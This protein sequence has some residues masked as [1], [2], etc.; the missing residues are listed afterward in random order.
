MIRTFIK[1][2]KLKQFSVISK[3][4]IFRFVSQNIISIMKKL[5]N[6]VLFFVLGLSFV[7]AQGTSP[8]ITF[9]ESEFDF[10]TIK[11]EGGSIT[12]VFNFKNSGN[13]PL[14]LSN[15][16]A[17]C[18]CTTPDWPKA[19][20]SPNQDGELKVTFNPSGRV[21][22][23]N[24]TITVRSNASTPVVM[25]HIK[26]IVTP[27]ERTAED[28]YRRKIGSLSFKTTVLP[29][30]KIDEDQVKI[31]TLEFM[32]LTDEPV[33]VEV[34]RVP[35]HLDVEID[36]QTVKPGEK[37]NVIV[38]FDAGKQKMYGYV[39]DRIYLKLNGKDDY[40]YALSVSATIEEDFS[41]LSE[42]ELKNAPIPVFKEKIFDF[43][44][45]K[46]GEKVT[47][48]FI[49]KNEGKN[50]LIIRRIRTTC[51]CTVVT[52]EKKIIKNGESV[53]LKTVFDSKGKRGRNSKTITVITNSPKTPTNVLRLTGTVVSRETSQK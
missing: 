15:V 21:G 1:R 11:E 49:L 16:H 46:E 30:I 53:E 52:P 29:F 43:G 28:I 27:R 34:K 19:P 20:I 25:L 51:G 31:D 45:I 42:E 23:F 50:D 3:R 32:N 10:G 24:K 37:G 40:R 36:P 5:I 41:K 7:N 39:L 4:I 8:V 44:T 47:H 14:I 48:S 38:K 17:S 18:G 9:A 22:N 13:S 12:H 33:K 2:K 6:I 26:G 35:T